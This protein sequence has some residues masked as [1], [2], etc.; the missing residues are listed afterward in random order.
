MKV[1]DILSEM[2]ESPKSWSVGLHEEE[3]KL[4]ELISKASVILGFRLTQSVLP[5]TRALKKLYI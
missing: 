1:I 4:I 5:L 3:Y 2:E